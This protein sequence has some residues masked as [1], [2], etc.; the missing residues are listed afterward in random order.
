MTATPLP[1]LSYGDYTHC[2]HFFIDTVE[3]VVQA[4]HTFTT[5]RQTVNKEQK[6]DYE[7][8]LLRR[9]FCQGAKEVEAAAFLRQV[10]RTGLDPFARQIYAI[11]RGGKLTV[12]VSIDG[13]RSPSRSGRASTPDSRGR[14]GVAM[15]AS[16][17][18]CG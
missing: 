6:Q 15:M 5:E 11:P 1:A 18:M 7:Q 14:T 9:T 16:G 13:M 3:I 12:Q 10:E 17:P 8:D 4:V 2:Q